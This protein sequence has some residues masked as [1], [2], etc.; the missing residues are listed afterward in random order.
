VETSP[1]REQRTPMSG[2]VRGA[3]LVVLVATA[4]RTHPTKIRGQLI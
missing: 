2:F 3:L 1:S 4:S